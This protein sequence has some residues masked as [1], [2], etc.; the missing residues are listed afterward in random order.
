M[1]KQIKH[2]KLHDESNSRTHR[3]STLLDDGDPW[4]PKNLLTPEQKKSTSWTPVE[5]FVVSAIDRYMYRS[6]SQY[7]LTDS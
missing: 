7:V 2:D 5:L 6:L 4:A 1:D 3:L